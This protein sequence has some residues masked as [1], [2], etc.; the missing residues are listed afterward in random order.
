MIVF[1]WGPFPF[2]HAEPLKVGYFSDLTPGV[3]LPE[4]WEPMTFSGIDRHTGYTLIKNDGRS[5]IKAHSQNAASGLIRF[6]RIDPA[7]Y[8]VIQWQWKI[9]HVLEKGDAKTRQGDDY[10]ARIY[11][12]FAFDPD[13]ASWWERA[14]HK[15]AAAFSDKEVPGSALNYIWANKAPKN[16]ILTNPYISES[17]MVAVQS[18]NA[19]AGRW[20]TEERNI[21][22]DYR[23]AFGR[24]PPEIIGIGIMTDTDDTGEETAGYYGDILLYPSGII[25]IGSF[26]AP[27]S[28]VV[29]TQ[30]DH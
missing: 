19:L 29:E 27:R 30:L 21:V 26:A 25:D 1:L 8:P 23:Q 13:Q 6:L 28:L 14:R 11:V 17:M 12:A 20:I 4:T 15:G 9:D 7:K 22:D 16:S 18:G 5:V 2:I 3:E 10:A 24:T